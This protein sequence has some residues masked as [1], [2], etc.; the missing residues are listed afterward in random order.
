LRKEELVA[1]AI[2]FGL[3]SEGL[4]EDLCKLCAF[5][6]AGNHTPKTWA[7]LAALEAQRPKIME[8]PAEGGEPC[9]G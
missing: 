1:I 3:G 7:R 6:Q 9:C 2:E 5:I 8:P 4:V